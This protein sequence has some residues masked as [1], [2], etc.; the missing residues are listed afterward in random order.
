[1]RSELG[2][3]PT[4]TASERRS[5]AEV[6]VA[7]LRLGLTSFGGPVAHIGYFR[8]EFVER[9]RWL[10]EAQFSQLLAVAQFLPGPA[11]SQAGFSI[12][13][14]SGGWLGGIAAFVGFT[15]P[16]ALLM[17]AIAVGGASL[18]GAWWVGTVHGLK[19]VAVVVVADGVLKMARQLTPDAARITIAGISAAI[20]LWR[21]TADSQMI[22]LAVGAVAGLM[23]PR[24][25]RPDAL[26]TQEE[27]DRKASAA[28]LPSALAGL[29]FLALLGVA[30]LSRS[31]EASLPALAAAFVRAGSLVFGGGHVVL[32]LLQESTVTSGWL[33]ADTFLSG[34]GAAQAVP[35]PM[36]SVA[37]YLGALTPWSATAP[38]LGASAIGAVVALLAIFTPGFLLV[39]AALPLWGRISTHAAAAHVILGVN[40]AVVGLLAAAL[41]NPV[42][43]SG[44]TG[45]ADVAILF[46]GFVLHRRLKRPALWLLLW[47]VSSAL[48]LQGS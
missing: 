11:S 20:V 7:F 12:G 9:R 19:L 10:G 21:G 1:M 35:G 13:L 34:Y 32:P 45:V 15:L 6:F 24:R 33:S 29:L 2:I 23:L 17:F 30:L 5:P 18:G 44:V 27:D 47:C 4:L 37:A 46:V 48:L 31:T 40:A 41:Y 3:R 36:F 28:I 39:A 16:S 43:T 8:A 26:Q 25:A 14:H 22:A 38:S 42:I